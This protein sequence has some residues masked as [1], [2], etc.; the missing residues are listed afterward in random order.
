MASRLDLAR[1][2]LR[3]SHLH[4]LAATGGL[5]DAQWTWRR[6][7]GEWSP[8]DVVEHLAVVERGSSRFLVEGF[9]HP[10]VADAPARSESDLSAY[11]SKLIGWLTTRDT[12][13]TAPERV[14]PKGR[15][16]T[17]PEALENLTTSRQALVAFADA[18]SYDLASK[19]APHPR[20]GLLDGVQ[21]MLFLAAHMERHVAQL[22]AISSAPGFPGSR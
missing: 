10:E 16:A 5:T 22:E 13:V 8:L 2:T 7:D 17:G 1:A 3:D 18:P 4:L 12:P 14:A 6:Q 21:W 11:D 19:V 15:F 20:L 9:T